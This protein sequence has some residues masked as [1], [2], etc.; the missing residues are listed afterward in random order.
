MPKHPRA[1][2]QR[3]GKKEV[4]L[5][6]SITDS[7]AKKRPLIG[8]SAKEERPLVAWRFS[9]HDKGG[10]WA[11][12]NLSN[13]SEYKETIEKLYSFETMDLTTINRAG[14]HR[15]ELARLSKE[16]RK[17]LEKIRQDDVDHLMSFRLSGKKRIWCIDDIN[18]M[19]I[20]WWDPNHTVCPSLK[21]HT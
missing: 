21:R 2:E 18:I 1:E 4:R 11:W 9:T 3:G 14:S 7:V 5:D 17:R 12:T 20:L 8:A 6:R 16:A 19:N 13:L 10:R 15:V